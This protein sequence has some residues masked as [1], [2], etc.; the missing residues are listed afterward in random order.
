MG[1]RGTWRPVAFQAEGAWKERR[2]ELRHRRFAT[3]EAARIA[4][5]QRQGWDG[6]GRGRKGAWRDGDGQRHL[7]VEAPVTGPQGA[8]RSPVVEVQGGASRHPLPGSGVIPPGCAAAANDHGTRR[9]TPEDVISPRP[10]SFPHPI[11]LPE[12]AGEHALRE[13]HC[14]ETTGI[15]TRPTL[16]PSVPARPTSAPA[17]SP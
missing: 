14:N 11:P 16:V 10:S 1:P 4:D 2:A 12:G 7:V 6:Y 17:S 8:A 15:R 3:G 13:F 9:A 5:S